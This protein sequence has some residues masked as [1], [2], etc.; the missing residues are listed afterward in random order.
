MRR[1]QGKAP[2][3]LATDTAAKPLNNSVSVG[4]GVAE[5]ATESGISK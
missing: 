2:P 1:A 3:K 4:W 5:G